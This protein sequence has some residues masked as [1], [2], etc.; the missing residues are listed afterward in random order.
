MKKYNKRTTNKRTTNKRTTNKRTRNKI[1][2]Q[3]EYNK[4]KRKKNI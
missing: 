3:N 4:Y 1:I 2:T